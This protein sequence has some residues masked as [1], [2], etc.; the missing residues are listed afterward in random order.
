[1]KIETYI[2]AKFFLVP[3]ALG[4]KNCHRAGEK[5]ACAPLTGVIGREW[6]VGGKKK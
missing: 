3:L 1:M 6:G 2:D 4:I 5:L